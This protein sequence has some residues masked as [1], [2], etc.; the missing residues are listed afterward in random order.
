VAVAIGVDPDEAAL[1]QAALTRRGGPEG[2]L[3]RSEA[4][5]DPHLQLLGARLAEEAGERQL[6]VDRQGCHIAAAGLVLPD[7]PHPSNRL[8]AGK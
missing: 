3:G 2:L 8:L 4:E 6:A 7:D 5:V 1:L